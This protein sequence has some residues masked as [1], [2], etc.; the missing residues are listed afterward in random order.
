VGVTAQPGSD[1][2]ETSGSIPLA[3]AP[4]V[5]QIEIPIVGDVIDENDERLLIALQSAQA[6]IDPTVE[7]EIIDDD[8]VSLIVDDIDVPEGEPANVAI[9]LSNPSD[10]P[11][12]VGWETIDGTA[13]SPNDYVADA[14][15]FAFAPGETT[16]VVEIDTIDGEP[17]EFDETF[18]VEAAA[19]GGLVATGVVTI[20]NDGLP[21]I[22]GGTDIIIAVPSGTT[23]PTQVT[24]FLDAVDERDGPLP[25]GCDPN[26]GAGFTVGRTPVN[27]TA[28]DS[29]GNEST[30]VFDVI[31]SE[32]EGIFVGLQGGQQ[33]RQFRPGAQV[34]FTGVGFD[35]GGRVI[36]ELRSDPVVLGTFVADE[37]GAVDAT[38]AIPA[39]T[40]P[41]EHTLAM[42]D[43]SAGGQ[44]VLVT[45]DIDPAAP[46]TFGEP[47]DP[48]EPPA[49]PD[50]DPPPSTDDPPVPPGGLP[51]T[52][53]PTA[54]VA[55]LA[56]VF[57][58][59]GVS[60]ALATRRHQARRAR[61]VT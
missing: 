49:T 33:Q 32:F 27:C 6:L 12:G 9:R 61:P 16:E 43:V 39:D 37:S 58:L 47:G 25:V 26:S 56:F 19:D 54:V 51:S 57:L 55:A 14:G 30:A 8:I 7:I 29:R 48:T 52:G 23:R 44:Q 1:F 31:V 41:G 4:W 2:V 28:T 35:P 3:D 20:V 15:G 13:T 5:R 18:Q 46:T 60:L 38:V 42:L 50:V 22:V 59:A 24:W 45:V 21:E 36:V 34:D 40:P 17:L 10:R 53:A 11:I